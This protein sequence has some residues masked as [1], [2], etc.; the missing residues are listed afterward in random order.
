MR[1]HNGTALQRLTGCRTSPAQT[2]V[3]S[4]L[5]RGPLAASLLGPAPPLHPTVRKHPSFSAV[6][7]TQRLGNPM[8]YRNTI[9]VWGVF[10]LLLAATETATEEGMGPL[11]AALKEVL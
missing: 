5:L 1:G 10:L 6:L 9:T 7:Q 3:P 8:G 2:A 4:Q 11:V